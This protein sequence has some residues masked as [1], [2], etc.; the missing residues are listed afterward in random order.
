MSSRGQNGISAFLK[1]SKIFSNIAFRVM[2][3][4]LWSLKPSN[5]CPV[6]YELNESSLVAFKLF[7]NALVGKLKV[8][9]AKLI[10]YD[11]KGLEHLQAI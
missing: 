10:V 5:V 3:N 8:Q 7:S 4:K 11:N 6:R 9:T 2:C 1:F